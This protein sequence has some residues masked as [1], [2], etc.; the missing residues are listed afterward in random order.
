M[1]ASPCPPLSKISAQSFITEVNGVCH[2]EQALHYI[3]AAAE[4]EVLNSVHILKVLILIQFSFQ[5]ILMDMS[6]ILFNI[7]DN[8]QAI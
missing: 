5:Y 6:H 2:A 3:H 1:N 7:I 4:T 8:W